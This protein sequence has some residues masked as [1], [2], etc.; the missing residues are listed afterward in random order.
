MAHSFRTQLWFEIR[1]RK[2]MLPWLV[3][4][5]FLFA[6]GLWFL[7]PQYTSGPAIASWSVHVITWLTLIACFSLIGAV[8][9]SQF[10]T[11]AVPGLPNF[12][13]RRPMSNAALAAAK[14]IRATLAVA[15][16][17]AVLGVV[18]VICV[19]TG[20]GA[21]PAGT[22]HE[23]L[24]DEFQT[25]SLFVYAMGGTLVVVV[26]SWGQAVVNE[27]MSV[28][29]LSRSAHAAILLIRIAFML[30]LLSG[31]LWAF[32]SPTQVE[33]VYLWILVAIVGLKVAC[34]A[35]L[36]QKLFIAG[37]ATRR[38]LR[39]TLALWVMIVSLVFVLAASLIA[40]D[41]VPRFVLL[42]G[43]VILAPLLPMLAMPVVISRA[44]HNT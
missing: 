28:F 21:M 5:A 26:L 10:E 39:W 1:V 30:A 4:F 19:L 27:V 29:I 37:P 23:Y 14:V 17:V 43:A 33:P 24:A 6:W 42:L 12:V 9:L 3:L 41:Y 38:Y 31:C 32:A 8:S 20:A 15:G 34:A 13:A 7:R 11:L 44:R 35:L 36:G 2:L 18:L 22:M 25:R 16:A 40:A